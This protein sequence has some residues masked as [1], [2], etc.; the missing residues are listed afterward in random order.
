MNT[1]IVLS[2]LFSK[3]SLLDNAFSQGEISTEHCQFLK[4]NLF[5]N[6]VNCY[7]KFSAFT[8]FVEILQIEAYKLTPAISN[9]D[10]SSV[11]IHNS[12]HATDHISIGCSASSIR[13]ETDSVFLHQ[14]NQR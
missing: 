8:I 5:K 3:D 12:E 13:V 14:I 10:I 2:E 9:L 6:H 4:R 1:C 7:L 11:N